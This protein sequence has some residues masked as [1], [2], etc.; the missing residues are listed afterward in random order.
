LG[1]GGGEGGGVDGGGSGGGGCGGLG[2]GGDTRRL[3]S[4]TL[5]TPAL[6]SCARRPPLVAVAANDRTYRSYALWF[7][8]WLVFAY[9]MPQ[10][11]QSVPYGQ[12]ATTRSVLLTTSGG[13]SRWSSG[14]PASSPAQKGRVVRSDWEAFAVA[15]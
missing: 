4:S 10:S 14:V 15:C 13:Y 9:R 11:V 7:I 5:A 2:G 8:S 6:S 1:L 12:P 3:A